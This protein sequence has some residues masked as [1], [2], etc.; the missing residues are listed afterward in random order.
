MDIGEMVELQQAI[1]SARSE[2]KRAF[3]DKDAELAADLRRVELAILKFLMDNGIKSVKTEHG[4]AYQQED[5]L[6]TCSDWSAFFAWVRKNNA[7]DALEKRIKKTFVKEM[8]DSEGDVPPGV[9][10]IRENVVRVRKT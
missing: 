4:T 7:F 1:K 8:L 3:E 5:I 10:I 2:A 6:P 9:S